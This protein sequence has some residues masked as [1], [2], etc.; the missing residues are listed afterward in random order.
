VAV[1]RLDQVERETKAAIAQA[2]TLASDARP[3]HHTRVLA[4]SLLLGNLRGG[5]EQGGPHAL[6]LARDEAAAL[7][8][9]HNQQAATTLAWMTGEGLGGDIVT[10][11]DRVECQLWAAFMARLRQ[12]AGEV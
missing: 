10:R 1:E 12:L 3:D 9:G 8:F 4:R 2:A 11:A 7:L 5:Q 6:V